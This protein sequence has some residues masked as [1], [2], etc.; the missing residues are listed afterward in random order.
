[1]SEDIILI[2]R[3]V[4]APINKVWEVWTTPELITM[5]WGPEGFLSPSAHIDLRVGG[6]YVYAM[7]GPK[8]SEWDRNMYS[9]GVFEEVITPEE[10]N[11][12]AK[13]VASDYF[14]DKDGNKIE[15]SDEGQSKDFP[16]EMK[17]TFLFEDLGDGRTKI[18]LMYKKP[19]NEAQWKAMKNSGM[20]EGWSSSLSKFEEVLHR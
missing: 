16:T 12:K 6:K 3:I 18:S 20:K 9:A 2:E 13:I 5:W 15:P 8:D 10:G 11:G 1:M 17:S 14:S 7:H 19:E 4:N